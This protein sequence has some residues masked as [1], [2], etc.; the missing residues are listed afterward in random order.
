MSNF[1]NSLEMSVRAQ[2]ILTAMKIVCMEEFMSI[3]EIDIMRQPQAGRVTWR[4]ISDKQ[5]YFRSLD[6]AGVRLVSFAA[7]SVKDGADLANKIM[8]VIDA[9]AVGMPGYHIL[10]A[11]SW[12]EF[13]IHRGMERTEDN[14]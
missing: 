2:R 3:T 5:A 6:G 14:V 13:Q 11:L 4:E 10:G 8:A 12:V 1:I 7:P 9:H